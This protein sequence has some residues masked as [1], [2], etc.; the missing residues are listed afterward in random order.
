MKNNKKITLENQALL[1]FFADYKETI[2][3]ENY[4]KFEKLMASVL[5]KNNLGFTSPLYVEFFEAMQLA[6][7]KKYDIVYKEFVIT[8]N[9]NPKFGLDMLVP[10]L[11]DKES[12]NNEAI[13]FKFSKKPE[14][15]KFLDDMNKEI[16]ALLLANNYIE[17][18]P[19]VVLYVSENTN[20]LK[21]L[22]SETV[23]NKI[24]KE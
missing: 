11:D 6:L 9:I 23:T 18:I 13:N 4:V 21:L 20:Q 17:I 5:L 1:D 16:G 3:K 10:M 7:E 12:S 15:N 22:F 2:T 19:N 24:T 14:M 8:F